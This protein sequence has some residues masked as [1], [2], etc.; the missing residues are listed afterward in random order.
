[1]M[2]GL[3][4]AGLP[5]HI[6]IVMDGNRRW[7]LEHGVSVL[8]GHRCGA[9]R[10]YE[11]IRYCRGRGIEHLSLFVFSM[12]NWERPAHEVDAL[13]ELLRHYLAQEIAPLVEEG[14]LLRFIGDRL[15]LPD[16]IQAQMRALE[17]MTQPL[18]SMT[19]YLAISYGGQEEM[20]ASARRY[21]K[22]VLAGRA[23]LDGLTVEGLS[24]YMDAPGMPPVDMLIRSSGEYR[25]SNFLLWQSAYAEFFFVPEYWPDF[26]AERLESIIQEFSGRQRRFGR[27]LDDECAGINQEEQGE[28][29]WHVTH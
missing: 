2:T 4:H 10:A 18:Q 21:L 22:D 25:M 20:V 15:A 17:S 19:L 12:Q 11:I 7:S 6:A 26:T 14:I 16:D 1:M 23:T 8:E 28:A 9:Q 27:R 24:R 5:A 29:A 3:V 13:M